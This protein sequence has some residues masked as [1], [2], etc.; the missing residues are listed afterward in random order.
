[1]I[2]SVRLREV[3]SAEL[4]LRALD[5]VRLREKALD[6]TSEVLAKTRY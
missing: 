1:V 5:C 2:A 3:D 4:V 6:F